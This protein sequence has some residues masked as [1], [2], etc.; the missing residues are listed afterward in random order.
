MSPPPPSAPPPLRSAVH[1]L[2]VVLHSLAP[3]EASLLS[4]LARARDVLGKP[5]YDVRH[6]LRLATE[7][8][9]HRACVK[10]LCGLGGRGRKCSE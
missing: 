1:N 4:Y 9:K 5:L 10:L 7:R 8:G 6:A 2:A 3:D